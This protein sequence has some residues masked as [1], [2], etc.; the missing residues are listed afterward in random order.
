MRYFHTWASSCS[1]NHFLGCFRAF[2]GSSNH[3]DFSKA[4]AGKKFVNP[5]E[6]LLLIKA[7]E[8]I[9]DDLQIVSNCH[10]LS[11]LQKAND[12]SHNIFSFLLLCHSKNLKSKCYGQLGK[13]ARHR[14]SIDMEA[15]DLLKLL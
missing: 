10:Q 13:H 4:L 1:I 12:K 14:K 11:K 7:A 8:S 3:N 9:L 6:G 2:D 15:I 5:A